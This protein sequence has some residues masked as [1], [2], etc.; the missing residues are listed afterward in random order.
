MR[1]SFR[2]FVPLISILA[3]I[4]IFTAGMVIAS[5]APTW[6]YAMR[7][8]MAGFFLVFGLFKMIKW[9]GF[10]MAYREYDILAK[11]SKAYAYAYPLIEIGLGLAYLFAWNLAV[12]NIVTL[13]VM[14]VGSYGIW[15]KLRQ[16]EEVPCACLGVVFKLPMTKVTLFED[17]T[18]AAMAAI[19]LI[20]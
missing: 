13:A 9:S 20:A 14:L 19:M 4:G 12:T 3:A 1:R 8:F 17:M 16:K 2:D 10:V 6:M 5:P 18:M 15:L 11:K 7:M